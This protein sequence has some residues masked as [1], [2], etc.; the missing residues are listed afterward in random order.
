MIKFLD[1]E[2]QFTSV[3]D[4][5]T[6][7]QV[8][9]DQGADS[10]TPNKLPVQQPA[11]EAPYEVCMNGPLT[12]FR[13]YFEEVAPAPELFSSTQPRMGVLPLSA[14]LVGAGIM[15]ASAAAGF[16]AVKSMQHDAPSPQAKSRKSSTQDVSKTA[17]P[18]LSTPER[19]DLYPEQQ[20]AFSNSKPMS[21]I[22]T[23]RPETKLPRLAAVDRTRLNT[24]DRLALPLQTAASSRL[25]NQRS[26]RP[27]QPVAAR[28]A[29][30]VRQAE[31]VLA[32]RALPALAESKVLPVPQLPSDRVAASKGADVPTAQAPQPAQTPPTPR[33]EA[34]TFRFTL[35]S[36]EPT[37]NTPVEPQIIAANKNLDKAVA[38]NKANDGG[39]TATLSQLLNSLKG[40]EDFINLPKIAPK[41]AAVT[42]L[43]L[44]SQVVSEVGNATQVKQFAILRLGLPDYQTQW[45]QSSKAVSESASA[46]A[47]PA[48]GFIDY[49]RQVIVVL[50]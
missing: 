8:S 25:P 5:S 11:S 37:P 26:T 31:V 35:R 40:L 15:V 50:R 23:N 18:T 3:A 1:L 7:Q 33:P 38:A 19:I 24:R 45:L 17:R 48:H 36:A 4:S 34:L 47:L 44:T 16:T 41:D 49:Q 27:S 6:S 43:P 12:Y 10:A 29:A 30:A 14:G 2:K 32:S 9:K 22:A 42:L 20:P 21:A 28:P 46:S 39:K 13:Y